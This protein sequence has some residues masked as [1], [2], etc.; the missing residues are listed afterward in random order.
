MF[1]RNRCASKPIDRIPCTFASTNVVPH[2][3]N[4]STIKSFMRTR[5]TGFIYK[6]SEKKKL[7]LESLEKTI[8]RCHSSDL[9]KEHMEHLKRFKKKLRRKKWR[10][11]LPF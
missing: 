7:S 9:S 4:G 3:A 8:E 1:A 5:E 11:K 2:P 10:E 6:E